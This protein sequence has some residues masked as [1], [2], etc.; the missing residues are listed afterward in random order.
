MFG[1]VDMAILQCLF[2]DHGVLIENLYIKTNPSNSVP[3]VEHF[4][5][6]PEVGIQIPGWSSEQSLCK[7]NKRLI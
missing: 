5:H 3:V 7:T 1:L 4:L 6:K 2:L